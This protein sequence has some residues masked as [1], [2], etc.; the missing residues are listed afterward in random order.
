MSFAEKSQTLENVLTNQFDI[1]YNT[2]P[3]MLVSINPFDAKVVKCNATFERMMEYEKGEGSNKSIYEIYHPS[4]HLQ[5][6]QLVNKFAEQG[7]LQNERLKLISKR[8]KTIPVLLSSEAI[9]NDNGEILFSN[10]CLRDIS[11]ITDL[12]TSLQQANEELEDKIDKLKQKNQELEQFAYIVSHDLKEPVRNIDGVLDLVYEECDEKNDQLNQ[13]YEYIKRS[14]TR[15]SKLIHSILDFS[16]IGKKGNFQI[17]DLNNIMKNV[18]DDM[19]LR[20]ENE[21]VKIYC[22]ELPVVYGFEIELHMLFQNLISNAIKFKNRRRLPVIKIEVDEQEDFWL[23]RITD[24][25]I[26][27]EKGHAK[28]IFSIFKRVH[29]NIEGTGIGLAECKK[30]VELHKGRIWLDH[31][32]KNG[33]VFCFTLTKKY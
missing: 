1:Y 25:G 8:G 27:I 5:V 9:R 21:K 22:P 15:M 24:N 13:Y 23:F 7:F 20:I 18:L 28:R 6:S 33:S 19:C 10:S 32:D 3:D 4:C 16:K 17:V 31:S 11:T 12:E 2:F 29:T 30:I 14:T 26:G